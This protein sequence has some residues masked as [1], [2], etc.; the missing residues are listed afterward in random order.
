MSHNLKI[1]TYWI[2]IICIYKGI[3]CYSSLRPIFLLWN[4]AQAMSLNIIQGRLHQPVKIASTSSHSYGKGTPLSLTI[5]IICISTISIY[6]SSTQISLL[7]PLASK[8]IRK[9]Q[10]K[11]KKRVD[12][13]SIIYALYIFCQLHLGYWESVSNQCLK[14]WQ[15]LRQ[16]FLSSLYS[17]TVVGFARICAGNSN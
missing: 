17:P 4:I 13:N 9:E 8:K 16:C 3:S 12:P 10:K 14:S 11:K 6:N 7:S 15:I 2:C 5:H 1:Q